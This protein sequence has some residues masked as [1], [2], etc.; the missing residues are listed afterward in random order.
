MVHTDFPTWLSSG[1]AGKGAEYLP[2]PPHTMHL[3][4]ATPLSWVA[5]APWHYESGHDPKQL[6]R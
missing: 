6:P 1:I 2:M 3:R 5:V 4:C